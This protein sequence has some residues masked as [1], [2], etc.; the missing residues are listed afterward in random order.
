MEQADD[1]RH[2]HIPLT[3]HDVARTAFIEPSQTISPQDV[4][5]PASSRSSATSLTVSSNDEE[6]GSCHRIAGKTAHIP[7]SRSSTTERVSPCFA[8]G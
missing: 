2:F 1:Q 6:H 3:E 7:C 5:A 4:R 8:P